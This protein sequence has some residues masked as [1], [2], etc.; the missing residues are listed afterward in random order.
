MDNLASSAND[1]KDRKKG[2][3]AKDGDQVVIDFL[4]TVD[5]EAFE[6]GSSEDYPLVLGSNGF[7]PGFEE[8]LIGCK[9]GDD[10]NLKVKFPDDYGSKDLAGKNAE[11]ACKVKNVQR[12]CPCK[13]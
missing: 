6:G 4:G 1:F 12:T 10:K 7:I 9:A 11:F 2:S 3:K 13:N 8:Q 5:G